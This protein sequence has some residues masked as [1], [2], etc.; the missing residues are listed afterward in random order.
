[1]KFSL[2]VISLLLSGFVAVEGLS[3]FGDS[4]KILGGGEVPGN[5]PLTFCQEQHDDDILTLEKV[6][7]SPNPPK[8]GAPLLIKATGTLKRDI[9]VEDNAVVDIVVKYGFIKLLSTQADLC[10]QIKNVDMECPIKKGP[11]TITK[12]VQLPKEIPPV[13]CHATTP[14]ILFTYLILIIIQ[15]KYSVHAN[16]ITTDD[17]KKEKDHITCLEANVAF[18]G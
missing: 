17:D 9:T 1:M 16:A 10:E 14:V 11:I 12:E 7:L 2:S 4:Q 13:S 8:A 6:D 18:G 3:L 15:G 5:N